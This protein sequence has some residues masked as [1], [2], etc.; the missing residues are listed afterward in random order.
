CARC[1]GLKIVYYKIIILHRHIF[2]LLNQFAYC[3]THKCLPQIYATCFSK[4]KAQSMKSVFDIEG[5]AD[6]CLY[7]TNK[8]VDITKLLQTGNNIHGT[9]QMSIS[10]PLNSI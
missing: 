8:D 1:N 2:D 3:R 5:N 10:G 6:V 7:A 4:D 9:A